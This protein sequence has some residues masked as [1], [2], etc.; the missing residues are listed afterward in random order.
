MEHGYKSMFVFETR[1]LPLTSP[2]SGLRG[3]HYNV[4]LSHTTKK[5]G[6]YELRDGGIP[7]VITAASYNT[8]SLY[9]QLS[10]HLGL[11]IAMSFLTRL[12]FSPF[13]TFHISGVAFNVNFSKEHFKAKS[14]GN[15]CFKSQL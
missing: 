10:I 11:C 9:A 5:I 2:R 15:M 7:A 1:T 6:M 12:H 4:A 13:Y 8:L 3:K 14:I